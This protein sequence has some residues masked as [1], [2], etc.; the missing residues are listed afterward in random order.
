MPYDISNIEI[1]PNPEL[2]VTKSG[3]VYYKSLYDSIKKY[4]DKNRQRINEVSRDRYRNNEVYKEQNK[5]NNRLRYHKKLLLKET[6]NKEENKEEEN[7]E[8]EKF[9]ITILIIN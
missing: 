9:I 7:K 6:L 1:K 5:L 4:N 8:E 2:V 3:K